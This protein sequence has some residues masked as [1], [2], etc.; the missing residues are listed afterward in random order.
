MVIHF[1]FKYRPTNGSEQKFQSRC[2]SS[3]VCK[4]FDLLVVSSFGETCFF[5]NFT[6]T[7]TEM[8]LWGGGRQ[9][10]IYIM[11]ILNIS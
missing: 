3:F 2:V 6:S 7:V 9:H 11:L 8:Y 5:P 10:L 1:L 4:E